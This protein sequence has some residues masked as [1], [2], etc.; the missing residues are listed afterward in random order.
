MAT[1]EK[2]NGFYLFSPTEMYCLIGLIFSIC[3]SVYIPP[4]PSPTQ[5]TRLLGA[6]PWS[7]VCVHACI[8]VCVWVCVCVRFH[9]HFETPYYATPDFAKTYYPPTHLPTHPIPKQFTNKM[10]FSPNLFFPLYRPNFF[11]LSHFF[12][13]FNE[14]KGV[15]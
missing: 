15:I 4:S 1:A 5:H 8:R 13:L 9:V 2:K 11:S 14:V 3:E 7:V 10:P 6:L 12:S